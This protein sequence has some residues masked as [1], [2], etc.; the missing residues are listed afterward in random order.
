MNKNITVYVSEEGDVEV[1]APTGVDVEFLLARDDAFYR[2][3]NVLTDSE[4]W[5]HA[6]VEANKNGDRKLTCHEP[7]A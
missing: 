7:R 6:K 1:L 5:A 3:N 4:E 2:H